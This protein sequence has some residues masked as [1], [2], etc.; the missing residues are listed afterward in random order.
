MPDPNNSLARK[1]NLTVSFRFP[2]KGHEEQISQWHQAFQHASEIMWDATDGQLQIGRITWTTDE[3]LNSADIW[4]VDKKGR[5]NAGKAGSFDKPAI[6][7]TH[8]MEDLNDFSSKHAWLFSTSD[9]TDL[10]SFAEKLRESA[11]PVSRDLWG[12][13]DS[14]TQGLIDEF[15]QESDPEP[16]LLALVE[17]LNQGVM[18]RTFYTATRFANVDLSA[19]TERVRAAFDKKR[20]A[21]KAL[22]R[23]RQHLN[24]LLIEDAFPDEMAKSPSVPGYVV[25][26]E[27][28]H[29]LFGSSDEYKGPYLGADGKPFKGHLDKTTGKLTSDGH[30]RHFVWKVAQTNELGFIVRDTDGKLVLREIRAD[31]ST[32]A[33][34]QACIMGEYTN[35]RASEFCW[36]GNHDP[37]FDTDH[38]ALY[39][40][41]CWERITEEIPYLS[42]M[43][44]PKDAPNLEP[45]ST[46][47]DSIEWVELS[48]RR[49]FVI[50]LD[51]SGSMGVEN[52]MTNAKKAA[53]LFYGLV[54][55]GD[56]I[57]ITSYATG[58]SVDIPLEEFKDLPSQKAEFSQLIERIRANGGT[59]I[60]DG[61]RASLQQIRASQDDPADPLEQVIILLS[62]GVHNNG[63]SPRTVI[64][65][66]QNSSVK[67]FTIGLGSNVDQALLGEIATKTGGG[68]TFIRRGSDLN[69]TL[70]E[71]Q[72]VLNDGTEVFSDALRIADNEASRIFFRTVEGQEEARFVVRWDDPAA[73]VLFKLV[74]PDGSIFDDDTVDRQV[75]IIGEGTTRIIRVKDPLPGDWTLEMSANTSAAA[76][77]VAIS[78]SGSEFNR[79]LSVGA[80]AQ[81]PAV[82]F[83]EPVQLLAN[84]SFPGPVTGL[85]VK[86]TV[87]RPDGTE[88]DIE[89]FDDGNTGDDLPDDG[90]FGFVFDDFSTPPQG[91][92]H[93]SVHF[94]NSA[95][96][97]VPATGEGIGEVGF[98]GEVP[99]F[100][101]MADFTV[102]VTPNPFWK[103]VSR[104]IV[105]SGE[106]LPAG[107]DRSGGALPAAQYNGSN[108][109]RMNQTEEIGFMT[110]QD[111]PGAGF[112]LFD[113]QGDGFSIANASSSLGLEGSSAGRLFGPMIL[114]DSGEAV[115]SA[116]LDA[117]SEGTGWGIYKWNRRSGITSLITVPPDPQVE[118]PGTGGRPFRTE[119][120]VNPINFESAPF[121]MASDGTVAFSA[122][123]EGGQNGIWEVQTSGAVD[124]RFLEGE[125]IT[126]GGT[127]RFLIIQEIRRNDSGNYALIASFV[128]DATPGAPPRK[129]VWF[130]QK[131]GNTTLIAAEG[132][133]PLD[134]G[135]PFSNFRNLVFNEVDSVSFLADAA[136]DTKINPGLWFKS[137]AGDLEQV[138]LG[139]Q[140][141]PGGLDD[142]I[143]FEAISSRSI[144][145]NDFD[146]I[147]FTTA[148]RVWIKDREGKLR[149]VAQKDT[150]APATEFD[151]F[152]D[153]TISSTS[154]DF[155]GIRPVL[156][157][158]GRVAFQAPLRSN[159][160]GIWATDDFG[161]LRLLALSGEPFKIT[162]EE[163]KTVRI[164]DPIR[165]NDND[166]LLFEAQFTD[167]QQGLFVADLSD[168]PRTL[169]A[170]VTAQPPAGGSV[171]TLPRAPISGKHALG[172]AM[173][174]IPQPAQGYVFSGWNGEFTGDATPL[175]FTL[176]Q[177]IQLTALFRPINSGFVD[178]TSLTGARV[179]TGYNA[180]AF[181]EAGEPDHA[182]Q[183]GGSSVW[184][185]WTNP[186]ASGQVTISTEGSS[187]DTVL[188]VYSGRTVDALT[189]V[190]SDDNGGLD[191]TSQVIF[192][193]EAGATY[194]IVVDGAAP[195]QTGEIQIKLN[196]EASVTPTLISAG[197]KHNLLVRSDGTLWAWGDNSQGQ[198]GDG[199]EEPRIAP[200]QVGRDTDWTAVSAG[201]NHTLALKRNGTLW[202]WGGNIYGQIGDGTFDPSLM[203]IQVGNDQDWK[204]VSAGGEYS[205]AIKGN[206]TLWAWG[207]NSSG[208]VGDGSFEDRGEPVQI[209]QNADWVTVSA[210]L[211]HFL[212]FDSFDLKSHSLA[213]KSDGSLWAWGDNE[214]RQIGDGTSSIRGEPVRIGADTD[215]AQIATGSRHSLA[216][217]SDQSLWAWGSNFEGQL[218]QSIFNRTQAEPLRLLGDSAWDSLLAAGGTHS[219]AVGIDGTLWLWGN[220]TDGQ[221]GIA[222][223]VQIST[224]DSPVQEMRND[225]WLQVF[226]GG[227]HTMA[228]RSDHTVWAWGNNGSGQLGDGTTEQRTAPVNLPES[229][230]S[231]DL[232]P[233]EKFTLTIRDSNE[234]TVTVDPNVMDVAAG[235]QVSL[236]ATAADGFQFVRWTG[237]AS[238]SVNPLVLVMNSDRTIT[239]EFGAS[240]DLPRIVASPDDQVV[241]PGDS[242]TFTVE[243][244]GTPPLQ[245]QWR[246]DRVII[247]SATG[248]SLTLT[249][250]Q[251]EDAGA[252]SVV[253][254]NGAGFVVG[255][256]ADLTVNV[257]PPV[258]ERPAVR[259]LPLDYVPGMGFTV[260][261]SVKPPSGTSAYAVEDQP[262]AGW[263]VSGINEQGGFDQP[264]GKVKWG[265]FFDN[266][267]RTFTC[268]ITPTTTAAGTARFAGIAAFDGL[269]QVVAGSDEV[270]LRVIVPPAITQQ[271]ASQEVTEGNSVSFSV[272]A[273]GSEPLRYQWHKAGIDIAEAV[274][275]EF[276]IDEAQL[277]DAGVYSVVV[278]NE[279]GSAISDNALLSVTP[280]L[281]QISATPASLAFGEIV[282]GESTSKQLT[283]ANTGDVDLNITSIAS[284][285]G[286]LLTFSTTALTIPS[287][288]SSEITLELSPFE[289]GPINGT[290]TIAA[291]TL[292]SPITI[293]A[294]AIAI[295]REPPSEAPKIAF[296][297]EGNRLVI[298]WS[299][300]GTL[301]VADQV[302]GPWTDVAGAGSPVVIDVFDAQQ[303]YR[304]RQ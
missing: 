122:G 37:D 70:A 157:S 9:L 21:G 238:G 154:F 127:E 212:G 63:E 54:N 28:G 146:E 239:A 267:E 275:S 46:P 274:A 131:S 128:S 269:L 52:K 197:A 94:D 243:A 264:N 194:Q 182:G 156:N 150:V 297:M 8:Y 205:V 106:S 228:I 214:Y 189:L 218:G 78:I 85:S 82:E 281:A 261:I 74:S 48:S 41:S 232:S 4:I 233:P 43:R 42:W 282:V 124:L 273:T 139:G 165:L 257:P 111:G 35:W 299:G 177:D 91:S 221:L 265:P 151:V 25:M 148:R 44:M 280:A 198:L 32:N 138:A 181:K 51:R 178:R 108:F 173:K 14:E 186:S 144:A 107:E 118:A 254:S 115:F 158:H 195:D 167:F 57:G 242:V 234:G 292:N 270:N 141:A 168:I 129:A 68:Y 248:S 207:R 237:D 16:L 40:K 149:I 34:S 217:K 208:Q 86:G 99:P 190:I 225:T 302:T 304:L 223:P 123:V 45:P 110:A 140:E 272:I 226:A 298:E 185:R 81:F 18:Q 176:E 77:E 160:L 49:R 93:V 300:T 231:V 303:F 266:N 83:P 279:A 30:A 10:G 240:A 258:V 39:N 216:L 62:D 213:I 76:G 211:S 251:P 135:S 187:F 75:T 250:V 61:L 230:F 117:V 12:T 134:Q 126:A 287:Q 137:S 17:G 65:D 22:V 5:A 262:P 247:A 155:E 152:A 163:E 133:D 3:L 23:D 294:Q 249:N 166:Q 145:M 236:A 293:S 147:A 301:Q 112:Y 164:P 255:A 100:D 101:R 56:L 235:S 215:W 271:P 60:G 196:Q 109:E 180:G 31:C 277:T 290:V 179:F 210:G 79:S 7:I 171:R 201:D 120:V 125:S 24:R 55:E 191:S 84:A 193:A 132:E 26:H 113:D 142:T 289:P 27:L 175:E 224:S 98:E 229:T 285:L 169:L 59:S 47:P 253:V 284:D 209:G 159:R 192:Q 245:Y 204:T 278:S 1:V 283:L 288:F 116:W 291:N 71:L 114:G 199:T 227:S 97:A 200:T 263:T 92:Y 174:L 38:E 6:H 161:N 256:P 87:T 105:V 72:G 184:W 69:E 188:G 220:N 244:A 162:R 296:R 183:P 153:T 246:K 36:S 90:T 11:D 143:H 206:G 58:A 67:V 88:V 121:A 15:T 20:E 53:E 29:Y 119:G 259:Q 241:R 103:E 95:G 130:I 19:E 102:A 80:Q 222:D 66:L 50:C 202:A 104:K 13:F 64:D 219:A 2:K 33:V 172:T 252:Y 268:E 295:V 96:T 260:A 276:T 73:T 136:S 89:M 203:P 286:T 170:D